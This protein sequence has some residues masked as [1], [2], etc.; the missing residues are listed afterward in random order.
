M[1]PA[2][3][4]PRDAQGIDHAHLHRLYALIYSRVGNR[5][6]AEGLTGAAVMTALRRLDATPPEYGVAA[7]LDRAA[8]NA[9]TDYW[10]RGLSWPPVQFEYEEMT[11]EHLPNPDAVCQ[12]HA[13]ES[14]RTLLGRLPE[15][16][17]AVLSHRI[18]EGLS[19]AETAQRLGVGEA[20]VKVLQYQA[21]TR[22]TRLRKGDVEATRSLAERTKEGEDDASIQSR[23]L[24]SRV[25]P[26]RDADGSGARP[27]NP[28][29][30]TG[31]AC[32][33]G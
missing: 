32:S 26:A 24:L 23:P 30:A 31:R 28:P 18:V 1:L 27:P 12:D 7:W 20:E 33:A 15:A 25:T 3:A 4:M 9:A 11:E 6:T 2:A 21:L 14:A 17:R 19:V 5:E 22:A 16:D 29:G 10:R 13:A 8:R